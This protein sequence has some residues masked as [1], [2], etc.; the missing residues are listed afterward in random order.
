MR[1]G[2]RVFELTSNYRSRRDVVATCNEWINSFDWSRPTHGMSNVRTTRR[3]TPQAVHADDDHPGVVSISNLNQG[4]DAVQLARLLL[5]LKNQDFIVGWEKVAILL[6]SAKGK[7]A[8]LYHDVLTEMNVPVWRERGNDAFDTVGRSGGHVELQAQRR[9][10]C[11]QGT[12]DHYPPDKGREWP[13]VCAAGLHIVDLRP[14][15]IDL[16]PRDRFSGLESRATRRSGEI[17]LVRQYY[18]ASTRDQRLLVLSYVRQ[19]DGI[20][21]RIWGLP[22]RGTKSTRVACP[23]VDD[24]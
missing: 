20:F 9:Q 4:D 23:G 8:D 7:R 18:V 12:A 10:P 6:P 16:L 2:H 19:P 17:D 15:E 3:I 14:N 11:G 1:L 13:V 5:R 24:S 21:R 22:P